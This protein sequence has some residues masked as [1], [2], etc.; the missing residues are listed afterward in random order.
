MKIVRIDDNSCLVTQVSNYSG[1][2]NSL[3]IPLPESE[4]RKVLDPERPNIQYLFPTLTAGQREFLMTGVT[5]EEWAEMCAPLGEDD[6]DFDEM[7]EDFDE[8]FDYDDDDGAW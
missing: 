3:K 4:V 5:E 7:D 2:S 1:C 6:E 8:D